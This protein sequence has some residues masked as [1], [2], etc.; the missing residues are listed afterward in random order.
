MSVCLLAHLKNHMSKLHG[1]FCTCYP[2]PWLS[3]PRQRRIYVMYFWFSHNG[4]YGHLYA[5][6]AGA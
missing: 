2:G 5:W 6:E 4:T 3:P 1:I